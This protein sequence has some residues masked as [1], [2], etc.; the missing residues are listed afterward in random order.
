[1]HQGVF[2]ALRIPEQQAKKFWDGAPFRWQM[3]F[4]ELC[5]EKGSWLLVAH[6]CSS[7]LW[8]CVTPLAIICASLFSL[9]LAKSSGEF[10]NF[11]YF[12]FFPSYPDREL[13][14]VVHRV[15]SCL[16]RTLKA[17]WTTCSERS[18]AACSGCPY[19]S[20]VESDGW[21]LKTR[22]PANLNHS[23]WFCTNLSS[24]R[25][26]KVTSL[27]WVLVNL[28]RPS[29]LPPVCLNLAAW[30]V[31]LKTFLMTIFSSR[32]VLCKVYGK[33]N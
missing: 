29:S 26:L 12:Y 28:W 7:T 14:K 17:T 3:V 23:G 18:W 10:F 33:E 15:E 31:S 11:S 9:W 4:S 1:M 32:L 30:V 21:T 27:G 16:W 25:R 22:D 8:C 20:R 5:Q 13:V 6:H 19:F 24:C 2:H